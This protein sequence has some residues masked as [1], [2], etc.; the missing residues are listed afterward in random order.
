MAET[1]IT[2]VVV[3]EVFGPYMLERSLNQSRFFNSGV[4][5]RN[6]QLSDLLAGGGKTFSLPFWKDLTGDSDIPSET[7]ATTVNPI[8]SDKMIVRRQFREKAWGS[9]D[10]AA[11][12]AGS[13]PY[14][15]ISQRV[16]GFWDANFDNL[17]LSSIQGVI[18]DNI[19]NDSGDLVVDISTEDGNAATSANKISAKKTIEAVMKQ[20]DMFSEVSALAVHS[21]VYQTLVE[22]DLIDYQPDSTGKLVI[23]FYMGLR[24]IVSDNMPK[25]AGSS[26]GY[27]YHSYLFK[28]GALAFGESS[29]RIL[30]V[31]PYRNPTKGGGVDE[32]YTRRQFAIHPLGFAWV[33]SSD[34]GVTPSTADLYTATSWDRVYDKKNTGLVAIVSNG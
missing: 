29:A 6:Q 3:P 28:S 32:L 4:M 1:R 25:I 18:A 11:A 16:M 30:N 31:E 27:K 34:T 13:D 21:V 33:K 10:L 5:I 8:T 7:V 20:G 15:A 9:N 17:A 26:S 22:N 19:A 12:L 14:E 23:P 24:V 2:N